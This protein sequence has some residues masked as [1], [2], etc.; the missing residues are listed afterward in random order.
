VSWH[1]S[2]LF[3][4]TDIGREPKTCLLDLG[5]KPGEHLGSV[6]GDEALSLDLPGHAVG[7]AAEW[8]I[9]VDP[10]FFVDPG[11]LDA[12]REGVLPLTLKQKLCTMRIEALALLFEGTSD[13]YGFA[14]FVNG[15]QARAWLQQEGQ[16]VFE[17]GG[18][19]AMES[20]SRLGS[21]DA[22]EAL[23]SIAFGLGAPVNDLEQ[24]EF[25]LFSPGFSLDG[26]DR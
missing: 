17:Q 24:L 18:S 8:T 12:E 13:T 22:E 10:L 2:L 20:L 19:L 15:K 14:Y 11:S 9:I 4:K 25:E 23:L 7:T 21:L 6:G 26:Y 5:F 16:T 1:T 3:L